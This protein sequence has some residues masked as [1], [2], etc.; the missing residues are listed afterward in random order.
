[1]I[2][3]AKQAE[4]K[5]RIKELTEKYSID[6]ETAEGFVEKGMSNEDVDE[7]YKSAKAK[8]KNEKFKKHDDKSEGKDDIDEG[9][10]SIVGKPRVARL[11]E[12]FTST[13]SD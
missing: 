13:A 8:L 7:L 1:M 9:K 12:N 11:M 2:E 6:T 4:K 10:D 3:A 5:A